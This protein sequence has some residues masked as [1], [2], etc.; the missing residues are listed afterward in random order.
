MA[1]GKPPLRTFI[2]GTQKEHQA[3]RQRVATVL[4][5]LGIE[6]VL[7]EDAPS[8][9]ESPETWCLAQ[10][11]ECDLT[12][13]VYGNRYGD[14]PSR[15]QL[16]VSELEF[17]RARDADPTKLILFRLAA[18]NPEA[19]QAAFFGRIRQFRDGYLMRDAKDLDEL[20]ALVRDG[21]L[22]WI[23]DRVRRVALA[24]AA[25][26]GAAESAR[27]R[28]LVPQDLEFLRTARDSLDSMVKIDALKD[29][30]SLSYRA[31]GVADHPDVKSFLAMCQRGTPA[32]RAEAL[33]TWRTLS[34]S[35]PISERDAVKA[36]MH[37]IAAREFVQARDVTVKL[38]ALNALSLA[39]Q[40]DDL[41]IVLDYVESSPPE[42]YDQCRPL[43]A[44]VQLAKLI[45]VS[46][47]RATLYAAR[48]ETQSP[49]IKVRLEE[50]IRYIRMEIP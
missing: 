9:A 47:V 26:G 17:N 11:A 2:T 20:A 16:S 21:V 13:G 7:A 15:M 39:P 45:G 14:I 23:A 3:A 18:D 49:D 12:I 50:L 33:R 40:P 28:A 37:D 24:P 4:R 8:A 46:E 22:D 1:R 6:P 19:A 35:V 10:A 48:D 25:R 44:V 27:H 34:G 41:Q 36:R 43:T 42:V 30:V 32:M 5:D 29:I 38:E 31:A